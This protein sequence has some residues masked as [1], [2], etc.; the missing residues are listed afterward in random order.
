VNIIEQQI[1]TFIAVELPEHVKKEL[2]R[3]QDDLRNPK[4][5]FMKW[6]NPKAMH[7]TLKFL[8]NTNFSMK[9]RLTRALRESCKGQAPFSLEIKGLGVFPDYRRPRVLWIGITCG[10]EHLVELQKKID[11]K[12]SGL[13]F[14]KEKRPFSPHITLARVGDS[15]NPQEI[16]DFVK[17][18]QKYSYE[19]SH[20]VDID[21]VYFIRSQLYP[22][23]AVYT[24]LASIKLTG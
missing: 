4:Q 13:G 21:T 9:E 7:L 20:N 10:Q 8:G 18:L 12:L 23:G 14:E 24:T 1:R 2:L 15:A 5:G 11:D 22:A 17:S 19:K 3:I 6:V 16:A